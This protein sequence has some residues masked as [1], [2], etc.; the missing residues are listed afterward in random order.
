MVWFV[1]ALAVARKDQRLWVA[2]FFIG[3]MIMMRMIVEL[4]ATIGYPSGIMGWL[5]MPI[6]TRGLIVYSLC[7]L[8]Y[9]GLFYFSP[10][11]HGA[12]LMAASIG[13]F[14]FAFFTFAIMTV[15]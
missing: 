6:M 10:N 14:F 13:F 11:A 4:M 12:L 5:D 2:G 15:L 7:Y 3:S 8:A 9:I 1:L